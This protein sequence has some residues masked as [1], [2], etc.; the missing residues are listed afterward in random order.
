MESASS[1]SFTAAVTSEAAAAAAV[2]GDAWREFDYDRCFQK[3]SQTK[4]FEY[5]NGT[6][7]SFWL[8]QFIV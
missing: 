4:W 5:E 6:K 7:P 8:D 2:I 1:S 3:V